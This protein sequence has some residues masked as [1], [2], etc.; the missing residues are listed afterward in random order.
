MSF[1]I[2]PLLCITRDTV[3]IDT[4][5]FLATSFIVI[6]ID[7]VKR[8]TEIRLLFRYCQELFINNY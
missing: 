8:L 7:L 6:G 5:A 4:L 2:R 1:D 3:A